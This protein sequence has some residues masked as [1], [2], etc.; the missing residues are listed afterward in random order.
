MRRLTKADIEQRLL[1]G[2]SVKWRDANNKDF[3]L[4]LSDPKKRRLL[5]IL[6]SSTVRTPTGL[7]DDFVRGPSSAF[8]GTD[9]PATAIAAALPSEWP[10][11]WMS[12]RIG[13][14]N[15]VPH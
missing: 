11:R 3:E 12:R 5:A 10:R 6:L 13:A 8:G 15:S 9:D 1:S 2:A 14:P 4:V 7:S